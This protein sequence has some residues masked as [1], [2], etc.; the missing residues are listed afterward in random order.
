[1]SVAFFIELT[2]W[3]NKL[4]ICRYTRL[5]KN[6]LK[7]VAIALAQEENV[8]LKREA[9]KD[10]YCMQFLDNPSL[11]SNIFVQLNIINPKVS[12]FVGLFVMLLRL[13]NS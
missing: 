8:G 6:S 13:N 4:V 1:M 9:F 11:M 3:I 2:N 7:V 10:A 5:T 12:L